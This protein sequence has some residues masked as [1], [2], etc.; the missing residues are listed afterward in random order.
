VKIVDQEKVRKVLEGRAVVKV[1]DMEPSSQPQPA[2]RA[3]VDCGALL[4][5]S[6][7]SLTLGK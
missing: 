7:K 6:F 1:I 5:E 3:L 4:E 2:S